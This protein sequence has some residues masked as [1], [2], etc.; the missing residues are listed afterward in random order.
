MNSA[1][2]EKAYNAFRMRAGGKG[3]SELPEADK[4]DWEAVVSALQC[5]EPVNVA[6]VSE[7]DARNERQVGALDVECEKYLAE[8][9]LYS[10]ADHL[11]ETDPVD[12]FTTDGEPVL[13]Q[14]P[15]DISVYYL[16]MLVEHGRQQYAKGSSDHHAKSTTPELQDPIAVIN[17]MQF[18]IGQLE[19]QLQAERAAA[20]ENYEQVIN[21][22]VRRLRLHCVIPLYV[23]TEDFDKVRSD[24][25]KSSPLLIS[26]LEETWLLQSA[27]VPETAKSALLA[28]AN[29]GMNR[30]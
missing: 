9:N 4:T 25:R 11:D 17:T 16:M 13:I 1:N 3:W 26:A 20:Q 7:T 28:A 6:V 8:Q 15:K 24:V 5:P 19:R 30:W 29:H 12:I 10:V 23:G 27:P 18:R 2:A 21:D 22:A 14:I